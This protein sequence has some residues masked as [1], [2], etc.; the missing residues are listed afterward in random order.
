M[1]LGINLIPKTAWFKNLRSEFPKKT[2]DALRKDCYQKADY[3]CEIC[4]GKGKDWPVECHEI[5]D[6]NKPG[7]QKLVRLIALCPLCHQCQ[8]PGL[9][10]IRGQFESCIQHYMKVNKVSREKAEQDFNAAFKEW[11]ERNK[12]QWKLDISVLTNPSEVV[13][14]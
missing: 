10:Q 12:I 7:I 2:W 11:R 5:W 9:A 13:T 6:F 1:K 14:K 4:G 8:H 3:I